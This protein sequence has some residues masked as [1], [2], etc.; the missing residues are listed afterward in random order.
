MTSPILPADLAEAAQHLGAGRLAAAREAAE[1]ALTARPYDPDVLHISALIM[2]RQGEGD[3]A[4][5][6]VIRALEVRPEDADML[7]NLGLMQM[8]R[9]EYEAA[10][11][12]FSAASE[13]APADPF[14]RLRLA[15]ALLKLKRSGEAIETYRGILRQNPQFVPAH[16]DLA[17]ALEAKGDLEGAIG[18]YEAAA[19]F[20][21]NELSARSSAVHLQ[22]VLGRWQGI[23]RL[24]AE[25]VEPVLRGGTIGRP[26]LPMHVL[27]LPIKVSPAELRALMGAHARAHGL[28]AKPS[29]T[30][31]APAPLSGR[32]LRIGYLSS[33]FGNH[34]VGH[35][36]S[37]LLDRH[38]RSGF[39]ITAY[40]LSRSDGSPERSRLAVSLQRFA[41][42]A[43]S[44]DA[45]AV[46]RIHADGI[47]ILVDLNGH[48]RH[49]RLGILARRP[50]PLQATWLGFAATLGTDF[51]DYMIA[52]PVVTPAADQAHY[53]ERLVR[54]P[55]SYMA[56]PERKIEPAPSRSALGLPEQGIVFAA[57]V[58][59]HKIEP[60]VF[61]IWTNLLQKVPGSVLWLR[62]DN[63]TALRSLRSEAEA[64]KIDPA[65][66]IASP[67]VD[68][69]AHLA[70]HQAAD[71]FLDTLFYGAHATALDALSAGL[72]VVSCAGDT[73]A[74][75]VGASLLNAA[76]LPDLVAA[77]PADYEALALRLAS[78]PA[79]LA[80]AKR[81]LAAARTGARLFDPAGFVRN[82]ETAYRLMWDTY[83]AGR[84]AQ[85]ITVPV[86]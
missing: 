34:P 74:S 54:L 26:P 1:R 57:F 70:R 59:S 3:E 16:Y 10:T 86:T 75:R 56:V 62:I 85:P 23:D 49:H 48:T 22:Q 18:S 7:A 73:F 27:A 65:R 39:D 78:D 31:P 64:R 24:R 45:A 83:A 44:D 29:F 14:L 12:C 13:M 28:V 69:A 72:P 19:R 20:D 50:A 67:R 61:G 6:R 53:A 9:G 79:A 40:A 41:D 71:L 47:D 5:D 80:D 35:I 51:V 68:R 84:A 36:V 15:A 37:G 60:T 21:K 82:L 25:I 52:D 43:D 30:F 77:T 55:D 17:I 46:R 81:R 63:E 66:L 8:E 58:A 4:I 2:F 11:D 76:G 32:K 33:D 38:D 42:I